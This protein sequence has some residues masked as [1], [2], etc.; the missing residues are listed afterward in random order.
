MVAFPPVPPTPPGPPVGEALP[1]FDLVERSEAPFQ[2]SQLDGKVWVADLIFTS[3]EDACPAQTARMR[4]LA[5]RHADA[6]DLRFLSISVDPQTDSPEALREYAERHGV[7]DI[8]WSFLT[9]TKEQIVALVRDG[10]RLPVMDGSSGGP[11][12][13]S[14]RFVLLDRQGRTRGAYESRDD[15]A[16]ARLDRDLTAVLAEPPAAS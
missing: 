3:C 12:T 6:K 13:H 11:L 5:Q 1:T 2:R 16:M 10:F 14:S 4:D 15:D 9:G 8:A 7:G